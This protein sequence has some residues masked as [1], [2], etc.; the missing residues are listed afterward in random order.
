MSQ[1]SVKGVKIVQRCC[2]SKILRFVV[3]YS[4]RLGTSYQR[5]DNCGF[6]RSSV[7][8]SDLPIKHSTLKRSTIVVSPPTKYRK[9]GW[10]EE[11]KHV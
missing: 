4:F 10:Q 8:R 7:G 5:H 1:I 6:E 2:I 3:G 11:K 9:Q